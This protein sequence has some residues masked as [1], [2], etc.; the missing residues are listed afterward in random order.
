MK[1]N[2]FFKIMQAGGGRPIGNW[3]AAVTAALTVV[4]THGARADD[5]IVYSPYVTKGQNE[6]E[7]RGFTYRDGS[8]D[9]NGAGGYELAISHAF[10]SW[11]K[12]ELYLGRF[13]R[14]PGAT[15]HLVGYEFENTFQLASAGEFWADPGFL[16]SYESNKQHGTPDAV[17]F[18]PLFEKRSG[19][20]DQRLNLIWEKQVGTGASGKYALRSAY[21]VNYRINVKFAP[22]L[23]AYYRPGDNA[24]QIGPFLSGELPA[25][26]GSEFEYSAGVVF[27]VNRGAPDQTFVARLEYEFF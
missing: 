19:R 2:M 23:E 26:A 5:F 27:G 22:G 8:A 1:T 3:F 9:T 24:Y 21:S 17:E 25:T 6:I 15:T 4:L 11:W 16:L 13:E 7:L 20:I 18:G 10:T 12:P 14:N